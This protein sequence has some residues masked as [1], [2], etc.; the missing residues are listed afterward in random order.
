[1][2]LP[3]VVEITPPL[4]PVTRDTFIDRLA[5]VVLAT[6]DPARSRN[7]DCARAASR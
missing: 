6:D 4:E 3:I 5:A 2:T 7:A 1:M